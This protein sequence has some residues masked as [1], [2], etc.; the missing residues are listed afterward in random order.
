VIGKVSF[1][2][3]QIA[4][5]FRAFMEALEK[6]KPDTSKGVFIKSISLTTTMGPGLRIDLKNI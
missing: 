3:A 5:N 6:A 1:D 4:D 2:A